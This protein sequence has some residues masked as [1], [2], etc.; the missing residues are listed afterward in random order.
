MG[1]DRGQFLGLESGT[2]KGALVVNSEGTD[3]PKFREIGAGKK[4]DDL[5]LNLIKNFG[6]SGK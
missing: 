6:G 2:S 4:Q 3:F 1:V 5:S